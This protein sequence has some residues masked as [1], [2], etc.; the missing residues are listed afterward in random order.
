M[1]SQEASNIIKQL[2]ELE[3]PYSFNKARKTA[4]L[5]AGGI[6]TM[7]KLF[8]ATG[9]NS[10]KT[11]G[12]RA[13]DTEILL[14]EVQSKDRQSIRYMQAVARMNYL[15]SRFRK[16]GKIL[17]E[18]MLH[19]LGSAVVELFRVVDR[20][21][22]RALSEVEKCAIGIFHKN[23]GQDME[24]PYTLLPS[25]QVGW[26]NGLH[27][28][29]ELRDWTIRYEA[30]VAKPQP[31][32][33]Q[34]VRVYVDS[35]TSNMPKL[36]TTLLRKVVGSDLDDTMRASLCMEAPGP[37]LNSIL[38]LGTSFRK[39][40]LRYLYLPRPSFLAVKPV[41]DDPNP[42]SGLYNFNHNNFQPWYV[43][44]SFWATWNPVAVF[45][46]S[47]G[48]RAPGTAGDRYHP[49]GYD[50][51]TIGPKPQEGKGLDEMRTTIEFMET[52]GLA[53][54]PFHSGKIKDTKN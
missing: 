38:T 13:V 7:S 33:D 20:N 46:R 26:D 41:D 9:Q 39:F 10:R 16:A 51:M 17:D 52:R 24:I 34:Y 21:E 42:L 6:P 18:D 5:K 29:E 27:F 28:A 47:L 1:T 4:L 14:R 49:S 54:C 22:W 12:K 11:A 36:F 50:L 32:N 53:D 2:Q 19:T 15:H 48:G 3:F 25:S 40:A 35:V 37:I 45:V 43:K 30:V 44:P 8:A 31:T 23:L